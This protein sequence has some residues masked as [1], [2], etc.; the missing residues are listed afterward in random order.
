[1]KKM[2]KLTMVTLLAI[3]I[4]FLSIKVF[5]KNEE[6][7]DLERSR[8]YLDDPKSYME[9]LN[10]QYRIT[11]EEHDTNEK[12]NEKYEKFRDK[13][14][15]EDKIVFNDENYTS[16][17]YLIDKYYRQLLGKQI[18]LKGFIYREATFSEEQFVIGRHG[19]PCCVEDED[20]IFGLLATSPKANEFANDQWI[21]VKG[22]LSKTEYF[23]NEVPYLVIDEIFEI[24]PPKDPYV[25][26]SK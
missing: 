16:M 7:L 3:L 26:D 10:E 4:I 2:L 23:I 24:E 21:K 13:I 18:E 20:A 5:F 9:E 8:A 19:N 14:I 1:M 22:T 17:M 15:K 12:S 6:R 11:D 25:Y